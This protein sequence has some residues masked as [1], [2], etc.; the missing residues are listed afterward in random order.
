M[1]M[2]SLSPIIWLKALNW[3]GVTLGAEKKKVSVVSS[4]STTRTTPLQE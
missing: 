2:K 1:L 3:S 4:Q